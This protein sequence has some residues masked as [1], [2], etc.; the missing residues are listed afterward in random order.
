M[1]F[2]IITVPLFAA[3]A[4][5]GLFGC[6]DSDSEAA[7]E[8]VSA[9]GVRLIR[10]TGNDQLK[11]SVNEIKATAGEEL[12]IEFANVGRMPKE[13]MAHNLVILKP[14][15]EGEVN[16]LA[17]AASSHPPDYLPDDRSAVLFHTK[18]LGPDE[19]ETITITAPA[20]AGEYPYLCT[21][22]GHF[23]VMKGKLVVSIAE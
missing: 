11:F 15:A 8:S 20:E 4:V 2:K 19:K 13:A 22:P 12:R 1:K 14:M 9:D 18:M 6:G 5:F 16:A 7:A 21:F 3:A 10:I 23:A 17:M